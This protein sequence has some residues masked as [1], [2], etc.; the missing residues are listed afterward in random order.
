MLFLTESRYVPFIAGAALVSGACRLRLRL[1]T[2]KQEQE[3]LGSLSLSFKF[4]LF[5]R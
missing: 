5:R 1:H 2:H 3:S 4:I